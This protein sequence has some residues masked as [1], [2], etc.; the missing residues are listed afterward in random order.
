M[1]SAMSHVFAA[2]RAIF[3]LITGNLREFEKDG[4]KWVNNMH[5]G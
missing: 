4:E 5:A 2:N 3:T 1:Y